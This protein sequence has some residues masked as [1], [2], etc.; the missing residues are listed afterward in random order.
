M[1]LSICF[2]FSYP[3]QNNVLHLLEVALVGGTVEGTK[4]FNVNSLVDSLPIVP[5]KCTGVEFENHIKCTMQG[6]RLYIS[7]NLLSCSTI[8]LQLS[9]TLGFCASLEKVLAAQ[10]KTP[11]TGF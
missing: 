2:D 11:L 1:I 6:N 8:L 3:L 9:L 4:P 10:E 7:L 5:V